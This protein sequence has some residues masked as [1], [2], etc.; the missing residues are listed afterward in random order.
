MEAAVATAEVVPVPPTHPTHAPVPARLLLALRTTRASGDL[1][2][3]EDVCVTI[4]Y[5]LLG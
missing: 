5:H 4:G 2:A 3:F 1:D